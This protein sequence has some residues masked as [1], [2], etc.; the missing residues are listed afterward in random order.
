[1][2]INKY[3]ADRQYASRR[4]ADTLIERGLVFINGK[5]AVL[6]DKVEENDRVEVISVEKGNRAYFAYYKPVGVVT[7]NAQEGKKEVKDITRF[8]EK[9]YPLGRLDKDS[10]G[11]LLLSNDGR[12]TT[13]LLKPEAG[14]EKEYAVTVDKDITHLFLKRLQSGVDIGGVNN[15]KHYV[16]KPALVRRTSKRTFDIVITEGKNRQIRR[17]CSAFGYTVT[18]L[19]RFRIANIELDDLT[20]GTFR[21]VKGE[22]LDEFL[23]NIN[24]R[25]VAE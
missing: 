6:G 20:S 9:V 21:E 15:V 25:G 5:K 1:M 11:L 12:V 18:T 23:K 3:L 4:E 24:V 7:V 19:K 17:M 8:P 13:A 16:T 14:I 10:E 2:R 22:E